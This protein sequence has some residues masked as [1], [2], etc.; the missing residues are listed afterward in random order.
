MEDES[1]LST[2][3]GARKQVAVKLQVLIYVSGGQGFMSLK[4]VEGENV[5]NLLKLGNYLFKV[6]L[7][8][9]QF[10]EIK[11]FIIMMNQSYIYRS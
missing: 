11:L 1:P 4:F 5:G 8:S 7:T 2:S 10:S 3:S 9:D 6:D